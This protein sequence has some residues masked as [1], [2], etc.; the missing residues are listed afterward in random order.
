MTHFLKEVILGALLGFSREAET[1]RERE[2]EMGVWK[3]K[4]RD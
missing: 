4:E 3:E 1:V 2:R